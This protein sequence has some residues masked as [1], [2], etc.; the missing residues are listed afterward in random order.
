MKA[1]KFGNIWFVSL[2]KTQLN[3]IANVLSLPKS[4]SIRIHRQDSGMVRF[5]TECGWHRTITS[6][7]LINLLMVLPEVAGM[8]AASILN[9]K[10]IEIDAL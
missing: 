6:M 8:I 9:V 10:N 7:K 1:N 5:G 4:N 3:K 2:S